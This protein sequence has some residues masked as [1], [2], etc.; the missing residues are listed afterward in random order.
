MKHAVI[1]AG[2]SAAFALS[3][4]FAIGQEIET[5]D[6]PNPQQVGN[7]NFAFSPSNSGSF[8]PG[9]GSTITDNPTNVEIVSPNGGYGTG[10]KSIYTL[11]T[12]PPGGTNGVIDISSSN[13]L[14]L[15]VTINS[16]DA[17]L[18][19]DLTD[20]PQDSYQYFFGYGLVGNAAAD[21][22]LVGET[23]TQ[24]ANPNEIVLSVPLQIPETG[25]A[26]GKPAG[27]TLTAGYYDNAGTGKF[28]FTSIVNF[29]LED[30]PGAVPSYDVSFN[31]LSGVT[32]P[33][34]AS[35]SLLAVGGLL[36]AR[37]RRR[38]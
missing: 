7:T 25:R 24:G 23:I 38:A 12:P 14:R 9:S 30:D 1:L 20:G 16:G 32:V 34:P 2:L 10:Y 31:D 37:R 18:F 35:L 19:V 6:S 28:D 15:D 4:T 5:F 36:A 11:D 26:P 3:S 17:G 8:S 29:R 27:N 22:P 13:L 21:V 33:E